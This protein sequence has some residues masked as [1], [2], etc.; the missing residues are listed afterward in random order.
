MLTIAEQL[1]YQSE[2]A[3][4]QVL[5]KK[6]HL[7]S[8]KYYS[9]HS[10]LI[11]LLT[12]L[13]VEASALE[14]LYGPSMNQLLQR[15]R[16]ADFFE[17]MMRNYIVFGMLQDSF[18]RLAKGLTPAKRLK[19]E[20]LLA[21]QELEKLAQATLSSAIDADS[22]LG[23]RM[24]LY[25]R[26][27]VADCLLEIRNLVDFDKVLPASNYQDETERTRA[28]FKTLEPYTSE[29]IAAHTVRMDQLGLT[30]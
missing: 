21:A 14:S 27:V 8:N 25:G 17:D 12:K 6:L 15:T 2:T 18:R 22:K 11:P 1:D 30:A 28:Q 5:S 7:L 26:M 24:A 4:D 16:G 20:E 23:H 10:E 13:G 29:L 19:V 9:K 3:G